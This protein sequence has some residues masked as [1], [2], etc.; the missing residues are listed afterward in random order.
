MNW[1]SVKDKLPEDYSGVLTF[2]VGGPIPEA[3][4]YYDHKFYYFTCCIDN[5]SCEI[6][7]VT[8][9]IYLKDIPKP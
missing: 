8:H 1:I 7:D 9:W 5:I 3:A 2:S 6:K 4:T